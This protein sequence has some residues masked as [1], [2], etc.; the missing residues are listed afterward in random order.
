MRCRGAATSPPLLLLL[1]LP[2]MEPLHDRVLIKPMEEEPV[3]LLTASWH[4]PGPH[5]AVCSAAQSPQRL[6]VPPRTHPS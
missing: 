6:P 5:T 4:T 2:Q 1:L 3:S